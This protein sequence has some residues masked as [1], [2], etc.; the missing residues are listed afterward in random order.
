LN[1]VINYANTIGGKL[2]EIINYADYIS[3]KQNISIN[4]S[5]SIAENAVVKDD[6]NSFIRYTEDMLGVTEA[7]ESKVNEPKETSLLENYKKLGN[8][9]DT[10][11]ENLKTQKKEVNT[12]TYSFIKDLN[13]NAVETFNS[14]N[15]AQKTKVEQLISN[16]EGKLTEA[17]VESIFEETTNPAQKF[18]TEMPKEYIETWTKL[19]EANKSVITRRAQFYNLESDYQI[20]NFWRNQKMNQFETELNENKQVKVEVK[21][22][23]TSLGYSSELIKNV[24][25]SLDR[26]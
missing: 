14:L 4:Y 3:E 20:R 9:I 10:V 8:K 15:E 6:F 22:Q 17:K 2:N 1:N 11:L 16:E 24:G 23:A 25:R 26:Y 18:I 12:K 21:E 5:E 19:D 13:E 7:N